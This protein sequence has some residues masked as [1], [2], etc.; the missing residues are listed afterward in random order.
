MRILSFVFIIFFFLSNYSF[1]Q[2]QCVAPDTVYCDT[3]SSYNYTYQRTRGFWFQAQS[4]FDIIAVRAADGNPQGI[5]ATRQSI[6]IIKFDTIPENGSVS[7]NPHTVVFSA[8]NVPHVWWHCSA[9]II[10]GGYYAVVGAKH[11]SVPW[12]MYNNYTDGDTAVKLFLNG[13]STRVYRAGTQVC[14][15]LGPP[16][17]G[18]YFDDGHKHLGRID[19]MVAGDNSSPQVQINQG[20]QLYILANVSGGTPPFTYQ[21]STGDVTQIIAPPGNGTYWA[22]VVDANG[23]VSDTAYYDVTFF[24][25]TNIFDN[26]N[27]ELSIFP[28]PSNGLFTINYTPSTLGIHKIKLVDILGNRILN[29][30]YLPHTLSSNS[31]EIDISDQVKGIYFLEITTKENIINRRLILDY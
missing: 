21:W 4:N 3:V 22:L 9:P 30:D 7:F 12:L 26:Q 19:I 6:E 18:F 17:N 31:I 2:A 27:S 20:G 10:S 29:M 24:P 23:C 13:D 15:G 1:V 14:L 11:D 16:Q 25:A 28:N 5:N 8:I